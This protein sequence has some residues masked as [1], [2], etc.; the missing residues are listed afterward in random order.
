MNHSLKLNKKHQKGKHTTGLGEST[1]TH[2]Q[3]SETI[4]YNDKTGHE[5]RGAIVRYE[6]SSI[7]LQFL[8]FWILS[9]ITR[10]ILSDDICTNRHTA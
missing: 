1:E 10:T 4:P 5:M 3:T 9:V 2:A 7:V 8:F 6:I